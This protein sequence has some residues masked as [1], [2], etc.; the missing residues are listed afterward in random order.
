M[1]PDDIEDENIFPY[2]KNFDTYESIVEA[3]PRR[4]WFHKTR[5]GHTNMAIYDGSS[6]IRWT[7]LHDTDNYNSSRERLEAIR[8]ACEFMI[9][10][11]YSEAKD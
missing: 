9:R 6:T 1:A 7:S 10:T 5:L 3:V 8:D 11:Y 4:V 2:L